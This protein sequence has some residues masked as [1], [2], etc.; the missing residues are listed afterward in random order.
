MN[1]FCTVKKL[2]TSENDVYFNEFRQKLAIDF[3]IRDIIDYR[4]YY[5][6]YVFK[7]N[8]NKKNRAFFRSTNMTKTFR[9]E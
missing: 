8:K 9:Q 1:D 4:F 5:Y 2:F 3:V 7:K 6:Y